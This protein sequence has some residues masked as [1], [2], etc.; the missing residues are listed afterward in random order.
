M[1]QRTILMVVHSLLLLAV[2][3]IYVLSH[4]GLGGDYVFIPGNDVV[5]SM[6][7]YG[8]VLFNRWVFTLSEESWPVQAFVYL[9][10]PAFACGTWI[11]VFGFRLIA[12]FGRLDMAFPF[13]LSIYSYCF[14]VALPLTFLQW[15]WIGRLVGRLV[16]NGHVKEG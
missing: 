6:A 5:T 12:L 13:G 15:Y 11:T 1:Y 16:G 14:L 7:D 10:I 4:G 9:N 3:F 8:Q 2:S